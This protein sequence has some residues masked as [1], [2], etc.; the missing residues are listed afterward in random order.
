MPA[1]GLRVSQARCF[2]ESSVAVAVNASEPT[3]A[4]K[5]VTA[6]L[7]VNDPTGKAKLR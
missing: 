4:L 5:I 7:R 1:A 6:W 3:P 2:P